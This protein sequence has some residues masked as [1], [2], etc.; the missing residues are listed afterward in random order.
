MIDPNYFKGLVFGHVLKKY[1][2]MYTIHNEELKDLYS[3]PS[4][5]RIIKSR[6][7]RWPGHVARIWERGVYRDLLGKPERNRP[8]G[9]PRHRWEDNIK[10][11]LHEVGCEGMD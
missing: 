5:V 11:V 2:N 3:S 7:I 4:I 8:L 9:R 10:M 1:T 6:R